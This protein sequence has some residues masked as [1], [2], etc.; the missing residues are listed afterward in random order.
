MKQWMQNP[1]PSP[2]N[3]TYIPFLFVY[4]E[5]VEF[6]ISVCLQR[7]QINYSFCWKH[8]DVK[9]NIWI[10]ELCKR[11]PL[12]PSPRY[13]LSSIICD[14]IYLMKLNSARIWC[15]TQGMVDPRCE[16]CCQ[17]P[18]SVGHLLRECPLARYVLAI[19]W[20]KIQ[21]CPN[22]AREFIALFRMLVDQLPRLELDGWATISW[23]LW[24]ARNK[25][26]FQQV[27]QH[28]KVI[29]EGALGFRAEYQRLL[30]AVKDS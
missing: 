21:K 16:F 28:P 17:K 4:N 3:P 1:S 20:G 18:E 12:A 11:K 24:N 6:T 9:A 7:N 8:S 26:Y 2:G 22:D 15:K 29:L 27:Q 25:Y 13:I 10:L 19:C 14:Y 23:A 5:S 30:V